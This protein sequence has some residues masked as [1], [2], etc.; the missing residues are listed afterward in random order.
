[1]EIRKAE[2]GDISSVEEIYNRIHS[3]EEAGRLTTG[4]LRDIYPT[5]ETA[6]EAWRQGD[7]FVLTD[8]G[9]ILG[10]GRINGVQVDVYR[11]A[12]WSYAAADDEVCVLH[13]LV[14]DPEAAGKGLGSRFV[15][16]YEDYARSRGRAE[17]RIDTNA[18]NR[19]ARQLYRKLGYREIAVVPTTFNGIP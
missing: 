3:A 11:G 4:W 5:R 17:L 9:K 12:P 8:G 13:T 18:R 15:A 16:Y 6:A 1:M 2:Q 14:I 19:A 10:A 7:L